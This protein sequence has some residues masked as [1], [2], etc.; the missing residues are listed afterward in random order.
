MDLTRRTFLE[1][2]AALAAG[3][4]SK[5]A[6][7][8]DR[9]QIGAIGAGARA[10]E[11]IEGLLSLPGLE[12]VG[13]VDA[14]RGRVA[15]AIE[16][17]RGRAKAYATYPDLLADNSIDAVV[18]ATPD[19][20]HG[21]MVLDALRAGKDIYCEKP[22]TF[23]SSEGVEIAAA[24]RASGRIVQVGSHGMSSMLQRKARETIQSGRLG[25]VT[26]I[27]ASYNRNTASGAWIYP[28][29]PDASPETVNWEMFLGP[30]PRRPFSLERFFRWRC[31]EDYSGG[32]STDLFVH[33]LTTIHYLMG[34]QV[35]SSVVALGELYIRKQDRDVP[36]TLNALLEY[37]EG[38][39]VNL[40]STFN[41]QTTNESSFQFLG[42][43]GGLS[44]GGNVYFYPEVAVEDNRWIVDSWPRA[45][46][47]A[48][49]RDPKIREIEMPRTR[50][51]RLIEGPSQFREEGLDPTV[52]HLGHWVDSLR[53]R[54]PYWEDALAGHHAAACAHMVNLSAKQRRLVEWDF[55]RDDIKS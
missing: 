8:N 4:S 42:T 17:T 3:S 52:V 11:L 40:C 26:V 51:P 12:I 45:L 23:R 44:L 2:G 46:A 55:S 50:P 21:R 16:R 7:A 53:T 48:Y 15:R 1:S 27:R 24:A 28:I 20:W 10:H 35:A 38:F 25:K 30:A 34:A 31:Y 32:L 49:Y 18:V 22:L 19:H 47:D 39:V 13:V 43:E 5:A 29:P 41:N 54:Q 37:P 6:T 33:L 14:Y 9:I 36:D